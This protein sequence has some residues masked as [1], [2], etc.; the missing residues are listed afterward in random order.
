MKESRL[1]ISFKTKMYIYFL[2][3]PFVILMYYCD[4]CVLIY[5]LF[6]FFQILGFN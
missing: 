1:T 6:F 2:K 4:Y 3:I 5:L